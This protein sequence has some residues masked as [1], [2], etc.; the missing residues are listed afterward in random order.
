MTPVAHI[1][2]YRGPRERLVGDKGHPWMNP[3]YVIKNGEDVAFGWQ[4]EE[5]NVLAFPEV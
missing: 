3:I 1:H 2:E 5:Q 4:S